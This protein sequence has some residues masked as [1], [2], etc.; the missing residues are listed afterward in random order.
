MLTQPGLQNVIARAPLI[1]SIEHYRDPIAD[2]RQ[3]A[4]LLLPNRVN[5][6]LV[7]ALPPG[8]VVVAGEV[9]RVLRLPLDVLIVR[10]IIIPPYPA[11]V[12]GALSEGG[13]LCINQ[14]L[15]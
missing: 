13:G 4:Q 3:L 12:A 5:R 14:A 6:G 11:L 2:G 8:C 9:A 15:F 7:L 1:G 10:E